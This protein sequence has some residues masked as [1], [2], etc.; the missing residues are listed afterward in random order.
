MGRCHELGQSWVPE[1]GVVRAADAGD[2]EVDQLGAVIVT[3][4]EGDRKAD[5]PQGVG[6][7][8]TSPMYL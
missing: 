3:R 5:L 4:A 8:D 1:D 2:V 6:G 7:A